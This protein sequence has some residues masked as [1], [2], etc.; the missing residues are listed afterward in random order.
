MRKA[1]DAILDLKVYVSRSEEC[2]SEAH[3]DLKYDFSE[4]ENFNLCSITIYPAGGEP[5]FTFREKNIHI[6][7]YSF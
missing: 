1:K 3:H 2:P 4:I 6:G 7:L 5:R